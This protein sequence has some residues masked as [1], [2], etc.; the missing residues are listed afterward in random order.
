MKVLWIQGGV[1]GI[2]PFLILCSYMEARCT[3][4]KNTRNQ[5]PE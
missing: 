4:N 1:G 3:V 5:E 2:S